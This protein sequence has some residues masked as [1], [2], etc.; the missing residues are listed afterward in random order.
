M[1]NWNFAIFEDRIMA[2][3][4]IESSPRLHLIAGGFT[5]AA[6]LGF[7]LVERAASAGVTNL[8][9]ETGQLSAAAQRANATLVPGVNQQF[10]KTSGAVINTLVGG[11][12]PPLLFLHGHPATH[13]EWHRVASQVAEKFTVVMT[14]VRLRL[15]QQT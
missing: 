14:D 11:E 13:V 12:G 9:A 1:C 10:V 4:D 2:A 3:S 15:L 5:V 8:S 6:A 7:G